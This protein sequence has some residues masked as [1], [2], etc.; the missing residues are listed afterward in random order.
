M[1]STIFR[2]SGLFLAVLMF[3]LMIRT[4]SGE[5]F[6]GRDLAEQIRNLAPVESSEITGLLLIRRDKIRQ[7]IPMLCRIRMME[8]GWETTYQS[9]AGEGLF[10]EKL[11]IQ[12]GA[13]GTNSYFYGRGTNRTDVPAVLP[14]TGSQST[15]PFAGSDFWIMDLGLEFLFWPDQRLLPGQMRLNRSC[16]VLESRT[17]GNDGGMVRVKSWIDKETGGLLIAEGYN[18]KNELV[19]DFSLSGSSFKKINGQ[20]KLEEM[21]I[22]SPQKR[23]QTL[24]KFHL[25]LDE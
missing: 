4:T 2:K 19:K 8:N 22:R 5:E 16:H 21:K 9:G 1:P 7:E 12:R 10:P 20:W 25:T 18:G 24:L 3:G 11:V 23:S 14:V 13:N 15:E 17:S 6:S